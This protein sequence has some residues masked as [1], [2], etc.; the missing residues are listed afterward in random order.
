MDGCAVHQELGATS[1]VRSY[2]QGL[3]LSCCLVPGTSPA[4][5]RYSMCVY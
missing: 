2:G 5:S 3:C 1:I 4:H